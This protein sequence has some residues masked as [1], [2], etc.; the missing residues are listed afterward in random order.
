[1]EPLPHEPKRLGREVSA[2]VVVSGPRTRP[3]Q[4]FGRCGIYF[5]REPTLLV[6][7]QGAPPEF[8]EETLPGANPAWR[9]SL[10]IA[11]LIVNELELD[12]NQVVA[13][14]PPWPPVVTSPEPS[15]TN[16]QSDEEAA[17]VPTVAAV[18][19]AADPEPEV[20]TSAKSPGRRKRR[21]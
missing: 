13:E 4:P 9:V 3:D 17:P 18:E 15:V 1:M 6:I 12:S 20:V 11:E 14:I 5:G 21:E 16:G 2:L 8:K 19:D 7:D 10:H